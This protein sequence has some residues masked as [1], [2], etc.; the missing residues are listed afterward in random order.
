MSNCPE[1]VHNICR[2]YTSH[3]VYTGDSWTEEKTDINTVYFLA[4]TDCFVSLDL[5]VSSQAAGFNLV[6][7]VYVCLSLKAVGP[8]DCHYMTDRLRLCSKQSHL[9]L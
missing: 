6:L 5:N 3:T 1:R 9:H 7:S 8:I 2:A 4:Q